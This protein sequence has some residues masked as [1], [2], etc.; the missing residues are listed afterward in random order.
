MRAASRFIRA[1][2]RMASSIRSSRRPQA[3]RAPLSDCRSALKTQRTSSPTS[4][5]RLTAFE[6]KAPRRDRGCS[7]ELTAISPRLHLDERVVVISRAQQ[8]EPDRV[9]RVSL[10]DDT[11]IGQMKA[12]GSRREQARDFLMRDENQ[13]WINRAHHAP[14][15]PKLLAGVAPGKTGFPFAG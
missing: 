7:F 3:S 9:A 5:R 15:L 12:G 1:R 11:G 4:R 13:P 14:P 6:P 10:A 2:R 8:P